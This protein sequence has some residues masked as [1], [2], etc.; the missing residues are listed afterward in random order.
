MN[1]VSRV[2]SERNYG[3][4]RVTPARLSSI[5]GSKVQ[6]L[7][8]VEGAETEF[9]SGKARCALNTFLGADMK[10]ELGRGAWDRSDRR[11]L[12][13]PRT[14]GALGNTFSSHVGE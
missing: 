11:L 5:P 12:Q 7:A 14:R 6:A 3:S 9:G 2:S 4:W 8:W 13:E 10:D 1:E